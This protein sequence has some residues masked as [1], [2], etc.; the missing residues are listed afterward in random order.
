[1]FEVDLFNKKNRKSLFE[2]ECDSKTITTERIYLRQ[3][4]LRLNLIDV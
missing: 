2:S 3:E 1:M 4:S